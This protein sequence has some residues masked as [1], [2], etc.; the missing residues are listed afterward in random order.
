MELTLNP[1]LLQWARERARLTRDD[2]AQKM[3]LVVKRVEEWE[4]SPERS[5]PIGRNAWPTRPTRH[6]ATCS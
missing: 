5:R 2:L 1:D 6:T 3:G 4:E